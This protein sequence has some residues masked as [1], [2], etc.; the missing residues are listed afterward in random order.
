MTYV[1]DSGGVS[2]LAGDRA[3]LAVLRDRGQLPL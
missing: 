1:L 2:R 3:V